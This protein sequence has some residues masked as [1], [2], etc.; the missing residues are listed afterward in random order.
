MLFS[1]FI[2]FQI[3]LIPMAV[4]LGKIGLAGTLGG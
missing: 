4:V 2:P 3:V 1:C